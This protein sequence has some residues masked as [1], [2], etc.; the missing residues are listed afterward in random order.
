MKSDV[1]R[2]L[3]TNGFGE[4]ADLFEAHRIDAE[5]L[6][7]LTEQHM[8]E[9]GIPL[10]P[11]VKLLAAIA[12]SFASGTDPRGPLPKAER[13]RLTVMFVDLV[14]STALSVR[15]DPE[16]LRR[17][18][19]AYQAIIATKAVL[20]DAHIGQYL[21]DGALLYFGY[22]RAHEDDAERSALAALAIMHELATTQ[23]VHGERLVARIGIA[24]GLVV[25]GDVH[26]T[27]AL[28]ERAAIGETP[29]LAA[30]LLKLAAPGE[31]VVSERT[32]AL[33]GNRFDIVDLG[34]QTLDGMQAPT[35]A[36]RIA[37][38]RMLESRFDARP[39]SRP[40]A[41]VDRLREQTLLQQLWMQARNGKGQFVLITGEAGIGKSCLLHAL[42]DSL[43]HETHYRIRNQCSP[44][45][46][47]SA[48]F[49]PSQQLLQAT[50]FLPGDSTDAKLDRLESALPRVERED[51]CL[52]AALLGLDGS[53]RY[54]ALTTT[55]Q[56]QRLRTFEALMNQV[57]R[58]AEERPVVWILED[59]H[60]IDPTTLELLQRYVKHVAR[61]PLLVVVTA[62]PEFPHDLT[63]H[64]TVTHIELT[65]F[66]R[67]HAEEV[68]SSL[69]RSKALPSDLLREIIAKADGVPLF[70][71]ELTKAMLESGLVHETEDA[72]LLDR[73]WSQIAVPAS[74]HD[75]LM[76]RL[77]HLQP[78]KEVAQT[79]ACIGRE[80][81]YE[82]L[83]SISHLPESTLREALQG[84]EQAG[85]VF[86]GT[87]VQGSHY[88]FKH[89]L[90]RD[91][92]YES[93][94]NA[95]RQQIHARLVGVLERIPDSAP[96]VIAQHAAQA[97]LVEQAITY[98]QK[99]AM[100][101]MARPA[102]REAIA[103]LTQAIKL[104]DTMGPD[105]RWLECR[106]TLWV[107]LGQASIPLHGY[108]NSQTAVAFAQ[109]RKLA[110]EVGDSPLR[111][112]I[113]N[114]NW[115]AH[116]V[117][118]EQA[119]AL[120]TAYRTV[121]QA[122]EREGLRLLGMRALGLSLMMTGDPVAAERTFAESEQLAWRLRERSR[123][124]RARRLAVAD[125]YAADPEIATQFHIALTW[126]S[127]GRIEEAEQL[128]AKAIAD[129][130]DIGHAH[131]LGHALAHGAIFAVVDR[132]VPLALSLSAEA[133]EYAEKHDMEL[134]HGYGYALH[135]F[136]L[137]LHGAHADAQVF[138]EQGII[139]FERTQTGAMVPIHRAMYAL[140][141]TTLGL[142]DQAQVHIQAVESEMRNG[143]ERYF[144][145]GCQRL[146]GDCAS[147][148]PTARRDEPEEIY[149]LA[150][151]IARQ[152]RAVSWELEV[153]TSLAR[154][155]AK[156]GE[157]T[158]ARKL[159]TPLLA[160]FRQGLNSTVCR[161]AAELLNSPQLK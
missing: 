132:D 129:A 122:G 145:P 93:L 136:A 16:D 99:A 82:L 14:G 57:A 149:Q 75:S 3:E 56:Q 124:T 72:F 111:F 130:R 158:A 66:G 5:A 62:R 155:W 26:R 38:E 33:L 131:T 27:G 6:P 25:V 133:I 142:F 36:Y 21:G 39:A 117:R 152:Q 146:L 159:L 49:P 86:R 87:S 44:Y 151:S 144:W 78:Y 2:W 81:D 79:A 48:L 91:A 17:V 89:A 84:L 60:W 83:S 143:A 125:R 15:L 12:R 105:R 126:W 104:A 160:S 63:A 50:H 13:R 24:T 101:S 45:H 139:S 121:E 23:P 70:L 100:Q 114:A 68:I 46:T 55:P 92:A 147:L 4:F 135:G 127:L 30:R 137:A 116:Y 28:A 108:G 61:L 54:G 109:A 32:R 123:G 11:R 40:N 148:R 7:L 10:G 107:T 97:G 98:W 35:L 43:A 141:L 85:L 161:E 110:E 156:R 128:A 102:Y 71:E 140:T 67:T 103:H 19:N 80:F 20:F 47:D 51:L 73:A 41:V 9:M 112:S 8:R 34:P 94:L 95:N 119:E 96:Q 88:V 31:I 65:R 157:H 90:L 69:T 153:A 150:L 77:D 76:A 1:R 64:G 118:G 154:W 138:L 37:G 52:I 74:L 120:A 29:N 53:A 106:L 18:I 113:E 59:A 115:S 22:P 58:L 42:L 134:W